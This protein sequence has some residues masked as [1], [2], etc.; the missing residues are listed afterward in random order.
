[1]IRT[2]YD[3]EADVLNIAFGPA[4][5]VSDGHQE[6]EPGVYVEVISVGLRQK[7]AAPA[8]A[9]EFASV[10]LS[11]FWCSAPLKTDAWASCCW[12]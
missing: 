12:P 6:V 9:A 2:N 5:A 3:P 10:I 7:A 1:M 11:R 4:D 8:K